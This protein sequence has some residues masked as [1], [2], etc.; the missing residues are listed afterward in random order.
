MT[1]D[2]QQVSASGLV[3]TWQAGGKRRRWSAEL[4][5]QLVAETLAVGQSV[6][7]VARRHDVNANQLFKWR[8]QF[9][10]AGKPVTA[11]G[12]MPV[13]IAPLA[14][15]S[16]PG[17]IEIDLGDGRRVRIEGSVEAGMITATFE[18]LART[19]RRR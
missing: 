13:T 8:R 18:G 6:S 17:L 3:D 14:A 9:L 10:A 12:L 19:D 15:P 11:V 1:E 7:V 16:G 4:K 2:Q 5:R